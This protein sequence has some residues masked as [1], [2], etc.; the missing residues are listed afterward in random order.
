MN[1]DILFYLMIGVGA[2]IFMA[3][4]TNWEW[5]FKQRR[6]QTIIKLMGR[7]GARIFYAI[8]GAFFA[9]FGWMVLS[10]RIDIGSLF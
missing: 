6:A 4:L 5:F 10:G 3:S 9:A 2:L 8:L 7:N 1:K